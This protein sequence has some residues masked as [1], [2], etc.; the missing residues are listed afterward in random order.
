MDHEGSWTTSFLYIP[1]AH[2]GSMLIWGTIEQMDA[3]VL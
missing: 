2:G 3:D 1:V